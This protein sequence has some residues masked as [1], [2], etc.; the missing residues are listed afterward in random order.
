MK[1]NAKHLA[2]Q[3]REKFN[4]SNP[5]KIAE[6]LGILYQFG[7]IGCDGCY[8]FLKNHRYIF[9]NQELPD[10]TKTMVMAHELGHALMHRKQNCYFIRNKTFLLNSKI[11]IEANQFAAEL[12]IPDSVVFE[13]R[14]LTKEQVARLCGYDERLWNFKQM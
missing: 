3:Y 11:E 8:M 12:L 1:R 14:D 5:F 13:N 10:S 7:N 6:A 9:I 2:V 4:T